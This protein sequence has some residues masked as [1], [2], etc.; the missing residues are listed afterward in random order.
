M[1]Y[2]EN[3]D[4][5][6]ADE[7]TEDEKAVK[8]CWKERGVSVRRLGGVQAAHVSRYYPQ[9]PWSPA[10]KQIWSDELP[11]YDMFTENMPDDWEPEHGLNDEQV[12]RRQKRYECHLGRDNG[13]MCTLW[14]KWEEETEAIEG[15]KK[16]CRK[17]GKK[18]LDKGDSDAVTPKEG[19]E[20][21]KR[22]L[23]S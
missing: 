18:K 22:K 20:G 8:S 23:G 6:D 5:P 4:E 7:I 15:M 21:K 17:K 12:E 14:K 10:S 3:P 11:P 9:D 19:A 16:T 13:G 2:M 1:S